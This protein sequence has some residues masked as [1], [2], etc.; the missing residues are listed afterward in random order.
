MLSS[1]LYTLLKLKLSKTSS[2]QKLFDYDWVTLYSI[3]EKGSVERAHIPSNHEREVTE[4]RNIIQSINQQIIQTIKLRCV[5]CIAWR[6]LH[7]PPQHFLWNPNLM[8]SEQ[9]LIWIDLISA[10]KNSQVSPSPLPWKIPHYAP[11][12]FFSHLIVN[13]S[14]KSL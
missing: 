9:M 13:Q 11:E 8:A 7:P 12:K 5:A 4:F 14:I 1:Y 2:P 10:S 6:S 3:L